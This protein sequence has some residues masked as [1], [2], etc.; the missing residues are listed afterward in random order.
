MT[1]FYGMRNNAPKNLYI[2]L[3]VIPKQ[4]PLR[5]LIGIRWV[6]PHRPS[7][8]LNSK[9]SLNSFLNNSRVVSKGDL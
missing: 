8:A 5:N 9:K 4:A 6:F 3:K 1:L 2:I 7:T